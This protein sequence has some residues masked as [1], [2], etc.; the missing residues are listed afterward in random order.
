MRAGLANVQLHRRDLGR[1]RCRDR[2]EDKL[3]GL[4]GC[5]PIG[6]D[7]QGVVRRPLCLDF[8]ETNQPRCP[9]VRSPDEKGAWRT[10]GIQ[11]VEKSALA[12]IFFGGVPITIAISL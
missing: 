1:E 6:V 5:Q 8:I 4:L 7:D 12:G 3:G 10:G 11:A 2:L 9:S